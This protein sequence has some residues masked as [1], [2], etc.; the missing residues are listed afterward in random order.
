MGNINLKE[1]PSFGSIN[2]VENPRPGYYFN[3][4]KLFYQGNE[5]QLHDEETDLKKLKYGYFKTSDRVFYNGQEICAN[6]KTFILLN[7]KN[8]KD[9]HVD[10]HKLDSVIG[11][12]F[13]GNRKRYFHKGILV[14]L[15]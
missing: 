7:R 3:K 2:S 9:H 5:I 15:E 8:V 4:K 12:D 10:L 6:P 1:K 13:I 11:L 14:Q